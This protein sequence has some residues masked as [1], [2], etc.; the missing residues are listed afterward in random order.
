MVLSR[1]RFI[2]LLFLL[3]V[4]LLL[5][6]NV[7]NAAVPQTAQEKYDALVEAGI[8]DGF[9]DGQAHLDKNMTRAQ[10]AKIVALVLG[11]EQDAS[12]ASVYKDLKDAEW[13]A[14]Y[15]GAATEAGIL[16][17]RGNGI[18][19]PS[20]DVTIEQLA[21]IMVEALNIEVDSSATVE[22]AS[23]WAQAYVAAAVKAGLIPAQTDYTQPASREILVAASYT[24]QEMIVAKEEA[25]KNKDEEEEEDKDKETPATTTPV[26]YTP[27][28]PLAIYE[29]RQVDVNEFTVTFNQS[30]NPANVRL[31][32]SKDGNS[33]VAEAISVGNNQYRVLLGGNVQE[34]Q[35]V[36]SAS[37]ADSS[38]MF[39]SA[40][41]A[42]S[43]ERLTKIEFVQASDNVAQS[44]QT[45]IQIRALNQFGNS[46]QVTPQ[47]EVYSTVSAAIDTKHMAVILD[48]SSQISQSIVA[49]S[50]WET[51]S[52]ITATKTFKVGDAAAAT[53]A[54][55]K[56]TLR[57]SSGNEVSEAVWGNTYHVNFDVL[58]QYGNLM[59]ATSSSPSLLNTPNSGFISVG[60]SVDAPAS[61][62]GT[63]S[64]PVTFTMPITEQVQ[65]YTLQLTVGGA[66]VQLTY[67]AE[68]TRSIQEVWL[69]TINDY[70]S[71]GAGSEPDTN[72][73][74][75]AGVTGV[76]AS[77]L[78]AV[79]AALVT[80]EQAPWTLAQLQAIVDTVANGG[81][82]QAALD[83]INAAMASGN[84]DNIDETTFAAAGIIGVDSIN[85]WGI[86]GNLQDDYAVT[87]VPKTKADIQKFVNE[88]IYIN[89]INNYFAY[90][91]DDELVVEDFE[92]AGLTGVTESNLSGLIAFLRTKY[93]GGG[94]DPGSGFPGGG[95]PGGEDPGSGF[96]G[97][98]GPGGGSGGSLYAGSSKSEV[99]AAIN[100]F[101]GV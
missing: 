57:D 9:P 31:S 66:S 4:G 43:A 44:S 68:D 14:G 87:Q 33:V 17:G 53:G 92:L 69:N 25:Q 49:V 41:V 39:S 11:L 98:G 95:F 19:D 29:F 70:Y 88:E 97:G 81:T 90:G 77:N 60:S 54:T 45:G 23:H 6:P 84:W 15:I 36:V 83:L 59:F 91:S 50:V 12:A 51:S 73:F 62:P 82:E 67:T 72:S 85:V 34:G 96:P 2:P 38:T 48:T 76:T 74:G 94:G 26:V 22:G 65:S 99:Q 8:F 100:E 7:G 18:F 32:I 63:F 46:M 78:A 101:L 93:I 21:K 61:E 20:S 55:F 86:Q 56:G 64:I 42:G 40:S 5:V 28:P 47:L 3:F 75:G 80:D 71:G 30:F 16:H 10:A 37:Y 24:A 58:D 27:P 1:S 35:Y 79:Q 89:Q 13:A 52:H